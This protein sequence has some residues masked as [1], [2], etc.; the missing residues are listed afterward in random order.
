MIDH[1]QLAEIHL[2]LVAYRNL[3]P[4]G[5]KRDQVEQTR[6][7]VERHYRAALKS[8][9]LTC[10]IHGGY[11]ITGPGVADVH[12]HPGYP[13]I[14]D[15]LEIFAHGMTVPSTLSATDLVGVGCDRP[16]NVLR[17]RLKRAAEWF[18]RTGC[19]SLANAVRSIVV[20]RSGRITVPR[21]V[22]IE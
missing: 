18:D 19:G 12:P 14:D 6:R 7:E 3:L 10:H 11:V 1:N 5:H 9:P 4:L 21:P 15:A 17:M 20:S 2:H 22:R 8:Q 16:D 13:G